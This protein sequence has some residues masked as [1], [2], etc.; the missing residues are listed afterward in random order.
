MKPGAFILC[1]L[2]LIIP[3]ELRAQTDGRVAVGANVASKQTPQTGSHGSTG[4]GLLWRIGHGRPGWG[5]KYGLNWYSA[6]LQRPL[7]GADHEFGELNV[8]PLMGGYGYTHVAG[9]AKISANVLGGYAFTTFSL[10][11]DYAL[12]Y[13]FNTTGASINADVTNAWV[14]KPELSTWFDI[15]RKVGINASLGY[16]IAR[17]EFTV[18]GA[19]E[20]GR[21]RLNA[22]VIM[23]KVGAVYSIF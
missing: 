3:A 9:R 5:W 19:A 20:S 13:R 11:D 23:I 17:P 16:M 8:R 1:A 21:R 14:V 15:N 18:T 7:A 2:L 12:A 4:L 22:D 10:R 6:E